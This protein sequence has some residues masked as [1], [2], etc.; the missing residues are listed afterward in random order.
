MSNRVEGYAYAQCRLLGHS[1]HT[2]PSDW[3]AEYGVPMTV[4]CERCDM[5]RRDQVSRATGMVE[6]R[7]YVAPTGYHFQRD[8]DEEVLPDRADFRRAWIEAELVAYEKRQARRARR[9]QQ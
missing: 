4:R 9:S 3:T 1:W 5:E 6:A 2:V 7:R 8:F